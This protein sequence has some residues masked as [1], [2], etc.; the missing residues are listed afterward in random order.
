MRCE[1]VA[2]QLLLDGLVDQCPA[3]TTKSDCRSSSYCWS[4][5]A[6]RHAWYLADLLSNACIFSADVIGMG[7]FSKQATEW[8]EQ[9]ALGNQADRQGN[10]EEVKS[11]KGGSSWTACL[12]KDYIASSAKTKTKV[13]R[14]PKSRPALQQLP[15]KQTRWKARMVFFSHI[16]LAP[17]AYLCFSFWS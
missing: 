5:G 14:L 2:H 9:L 12:I 3:E 10:L 7:G 17:D 1:S 8:W 16:V 6:A 4:I 11:K 13:A 15:R